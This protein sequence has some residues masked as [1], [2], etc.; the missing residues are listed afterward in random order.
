MD[1]LCSDH[2][3]IELRLDSSRRR[4]FG[5]PKKLFKFEETWTR[6]ETCKELITINGD[7]SGERPTSLKNSLNS[8]S[9]ALSKRGKEVDARRKKENFG[10]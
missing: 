7:W 8:C 4:T 3:P 6:Y 5:R 10:V 9:V 1:W 2:K